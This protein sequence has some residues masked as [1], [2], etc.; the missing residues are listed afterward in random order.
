[1]KG[2]DGINLNKTYLKTSCRNNKIIDVCDMILRCMCIL[3]LVMNS[4][5]NDG[6]AF[7]VMSTIIMLISIASYP[8]KFLCYDKIFFC[9]NEL[10]FESSLNFTKVMPSEES[11]LFKIAE[12]GIDSP[13][14]AAWHIGDGDYL[15]AVTPAVSQYIL[16]KCKKNDE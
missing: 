6:D 11:P 12:N 3:M 10:W 7:M 8:L 14:F 13:T 16:Q 1:M 4:I 5:A 9:E 15:T 2:P